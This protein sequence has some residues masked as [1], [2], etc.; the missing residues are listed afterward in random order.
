MGFSNGQS[1]CLHNRTEFYKQQ[2]NFA[3]HAKVKHSLIKDVN[4]S[5]H[6]MKLQNLAADALK[7]KNS[8]EA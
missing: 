5:S 2:N 3:S 1:T 4:H 7:Q 6:S 8:P